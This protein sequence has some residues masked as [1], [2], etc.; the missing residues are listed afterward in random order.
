MKSISRSSEFRE[1]INGEINQ[2][3]QATYIGQCLAA[4]GLTSIDE[5]TRTSN[6]NYII[7]GNFR[8]FE[9]EVDTVV[10]LP[11]C[12]FKELNNFC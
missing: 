6:S 12:E 9:V 11:F 10:D 1:I 2:P 5:I 4:S 7:H 8:S 3:F